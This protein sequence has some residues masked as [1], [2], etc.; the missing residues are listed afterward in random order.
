M[1]PPPKSSARVRRGV[2]ERDLVAAASAAR[3]RA[4]A[5]YSG[6][7]VGAAIATRGGHIHA[8]CNV[9]NA[10]YGATICAERSA[11]AAMIAAGDRDPVVC[12]V[13]TP[14]GVAR[15]ATARVLRH[16]RARPG[17]PCGICRQ[18]LCEFAKDMRLLL[19]SEDDAG[20]VVARSVVRLEALLPQAFRLESVTRTRA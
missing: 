14:A 3:E 10:S 5:P 18:V 7:R 6:F 17:A 2:P 12:V 9:E 4:Y 11:I 20:R 16:G 13:I 15:Q 19:I 8:G 1:S